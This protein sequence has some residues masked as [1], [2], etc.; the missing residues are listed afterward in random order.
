MKKIPKWNP[1]VQT[2]RLVG[3]LT[4]KYYHLMAMALSML[5]LSMP[6]YAASEAAKKVE[7]AINDGVDIGKAIYRLF[8][9]LI[10]LGG[11]YGLYWGV[12]EFMRGVRTDNREGNK[13]KGAIVALVGIIAMAWTFWTADLA[14]II[15]QGQSNGVKGVKE[16]DIGL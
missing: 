15:T 3:F 8:P 14:S 5:T 11:A 2:K 9:V 7:G 13:T 16:M 4:N 1:L 10:I 6:T 12:M